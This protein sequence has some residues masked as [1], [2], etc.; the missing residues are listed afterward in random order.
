[1]ENRSTEDYI[2]SIFQLGRKG[3]MVST[4]ALARQLGVR[5]GSITGMLKSLALRNL[6]RY[7]RYRGV[8]LTARGRRIALQTIRRHRLWEVF[9]VQ[10]LGYSWDQVH[11]EA[12]R[13]EH[14]TSEKLEK[15][16]DRVLGYPGFDP[17]GDPIPTVRGQIDVELKTRLTDCRPGW[18]AVVR[19]VSDRNSAT[20]K[21]LADMGLGIDS[22][23]RVTGKGE[24]DGSITIVVGRT[25]RLLERQIAESIFV[26]S[27]RLRT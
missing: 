1:M 25:T 15:H 27:R 22:R 26:V 24:P 4:S 11:V 17:H 5:N 20:L 8:S 19:R 23:L 6:V 21:H 13:L 18:T 3:G 10:S 12:E 7:E 9:L 16:L 2:K 14:V